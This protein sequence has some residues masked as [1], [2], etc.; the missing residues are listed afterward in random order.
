MRAI[1]SVS[2]FAP[3]SSACALLLR[4]LRS[5]LLALVF[6]LACT[7]I[8]AT[9]QKGGRR[10]AGGFERGGGQEFPAL[11]EQGR[12]AFR[13]RDMAGAEDAVRQAISIAERGGVERRLGPAYG[14]LGNVLAV[15]GKYAEA[16]PVLR[17]AIALLEQDFGPS[18][19]TTLGTL[20]WLGHAL[21][22]Q[23]RLAEAVEQ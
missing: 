17:K 7:A 15:R 8:D 16:E 9:A 6:A 22:G 11:L 21:R 2:C 18:G 3:E 23:G 14:L 1:R 19:K 4:G 13:N 20:I 10:G 12:E 5:L